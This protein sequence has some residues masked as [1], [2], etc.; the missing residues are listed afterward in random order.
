MGFSQAGTKI[1]EVPAGVNN[2]LEAIDINIADHRNN[3]HFVSSR[4]W[5]GE[6]DAINLG[7]LKATVDRDAA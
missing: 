2:N 7:K 4:A 5:R 1:K 6:A 3:F